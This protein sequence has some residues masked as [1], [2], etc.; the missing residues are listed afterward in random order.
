MHREKAACNNCHKRIDPWGVVFENFD[1]VGQWRT[2]V[3]ESKRQ[4]RARQPVD[5]VV[6]L[7]DGTGVDGV[8]GRVGVKN[9]LVTVQ[10]E[11]FA[12][13]LVKRL[14]TYSLGRSLE[15]SDRQ[16]VDALTRRFIKSDYRLKELI[17][18]IS[19][20]QPIVSK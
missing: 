4:R 20:S 10:G 7:P 8:D 12:R 16:A 18:A 13:A 3:T 17:V 6:E 9:Y 5:A 1:A 14:L 19:G 15:Y 2:V 11:A